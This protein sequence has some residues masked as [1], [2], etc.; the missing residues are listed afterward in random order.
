M[1]RKQRDEIG[2]SGFP[3]FS[4]LSHISQTRSSR[5]K[6]PGDTNAYMEAKFLQSCPALCDPMDCS[7]P[8]S[9]VPGI[10]PARILKWVAMPS[11]RGS[12]QPRDQTR[13]SCVSC[14][15]RQVL[16]HWSHL[17]HL[18]TLMKMK[19]TQL[20]LTLC[21]PRDYTVHGIL[22]ARILEWAAVPFSRGSSQSRYR[23]QVSCIAAG[24][25]TS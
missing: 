20:C 7:P 12:S 16:Y 2:G 8:G 5:S 21:D 6:R 19:V 17:G 22:H 9:S 14:I 24:I 10:L 1:A 11:S 25:F 13:V 15:G 18:G 23:T 4:V 3:G